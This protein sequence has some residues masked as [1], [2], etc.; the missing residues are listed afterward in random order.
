MTE[1]EDAFR[2]II[3]ELQTHVSGIAELSQALHEEKEFPRGH[4]VNDDTVEKKRKEAED[5]F[6]KLGKAVD[7]FFE[8]GCLVEGV[9]K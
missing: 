4:G 5:R 9:E 2:K 7:S 6:L 8:K 1:C 3:V